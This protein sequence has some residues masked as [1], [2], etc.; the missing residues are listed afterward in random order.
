M[1][2]AYRKPTHCPTGHEY[3]GDNL[4]HDAS[5]RL[6]CLMC[7]AQHVP[8]WVRELGAV[9][10]AGT[11]AVPLSGGRGESIVEA[12]DLHLVSHCSWRLDSHGYASTS[13]KTGGVQRKQYMHRLILGAVAGQEVDHAN[14][15]RLDN[16]RANLRL[17]N[18]S[19]QSANTRLIVAHNKS[20]YRGVSWSTRR[21]KWRAVIQADGRFM[22]LGCFT[23]PIDAALAYD[24][25]AL[26]HF[27]EFA[28]INFPKAAA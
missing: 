18:R 15:D 14:K 6:V 11:I 24:A 22:D 1:T 12:A 10:P 25:A 5:G 8:T 7:R 4:F 13:I 27:G 3:T 16:R 20:G 9:D 26:H 28:T 17:A 23:D 19:Q 2:G 21:A